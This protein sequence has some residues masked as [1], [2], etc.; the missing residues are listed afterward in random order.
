M[1]ELLDSSALLGDTQAMRSRFNEDGYLF[2]RQQIEPE[3]LL[4]LR[5]SITSICQRHGWLAANTDPLEA[6][7]DHQ[8]VVEGEEAY[9]PVYDDIQRLESFH[10]LAHHHKLMELMQALLGPSAFPH[11]LSIC[12]LVFP[13]NVEW[14][15]PPHQDYPN[16]QGTRDL[17]ASWLPLGDC[18]I[19]LGPLAILKG[20]QQLGLL[21]LTFSLGAG[22]RQ[23]VLDERHE[24]LEWHSADFAAGDLLI[25]HSLTVHR[26]LPNL[27]NRMRLSVDFRYQREHE[28]LT[29]QSLL[30]HFNRESWDSIYQGWS[31]TSLQ[32]Y[33]KNKS[34]K[35]N[36]WDSSFQELPE[37]EWQESLKQRIRYDRQL[38]QRYAK[39]GANTPEQG[40]IN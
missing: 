2:L 20:S 4:A 8:P 18:P 22:H 25:F 19:E 33:W 28:A 13:D 15:T 36:A 1:Q 38:A 37:E 40:S 34:Y 5:S 7:S 6:I 39:R 32:Y 21:P 27:S 16:N 14:S 23:C 11:P 3:V 26:A 35:L 31:N 17:L 30:P 10:A 24:E 12:R 29:E 9:F